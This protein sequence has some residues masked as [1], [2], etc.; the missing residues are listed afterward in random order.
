MG[1]K[2]ETGWAETSNH[3]NALSNCDGCDEWIR[4]GKDSLA[5]TRVHNRYRSRLFNPMNVSRGLATTNHIGRYRHTFGYSPY[6]VRI[7]ATDEWASPTASILMA[8]D[9][10]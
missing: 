9:R 4:E 8:M 2:V 3:F 6:D 5:W 1:I 10:L 7:T